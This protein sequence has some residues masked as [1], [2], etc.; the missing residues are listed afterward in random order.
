MGTAY[1]VWTGIGAA[2]AM[3]VGILFWNDPLTF[4]RILG[5]MLIVG[6]VVMLKLAS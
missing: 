4:W 2:G 6:G 5:V 1:A 3:A